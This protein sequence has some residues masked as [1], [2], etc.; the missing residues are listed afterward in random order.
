M[1]YIYISLTYITF[2]QGT[3]FP[4]MLWDSEEELNSTLQVNPHLEK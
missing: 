3:K 1:F 4:K 2:V